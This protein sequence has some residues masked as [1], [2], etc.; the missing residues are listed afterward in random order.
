MS[1][2]GRGDSGLAVP[3]SAVKKITLLNLGSH[4]DL[5][6]GEWAALARRIDEVLQQSTQV[7]NFPQYFENRHK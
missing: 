2:W 6:K 5:P 7:K 3:A 1:I 4:F